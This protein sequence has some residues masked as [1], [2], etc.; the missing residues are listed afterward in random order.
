MEAY[1]VTFAGSHAKI[2]SRYLWLRSVEVSERLAR[3]D[4][5]LLEAELSAEASTLRLLAWELEVGDLGKDLDA[6]SLRFPRANRF[7]L[8]LSIWEV[9]SF[10]AV[11][12]GQWWRSL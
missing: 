1:T 6:G 8:A 9:L 3:A 11:S 10:L 7:Q 4:D 5:A 2:L 12:I